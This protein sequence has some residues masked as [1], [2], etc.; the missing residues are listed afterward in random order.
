MKITIDYDNGV[1]TTDNKIEA[2]I[3][4]LL[5]IGEDFSIGSE[6]GLYALRIHVLRGFVNPSDF[7]L[8]DKSLKEEVY[9]DEQGKLSNYGDSIFDSYLDEL[10][11]I[12]YSWKEGE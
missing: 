6:I 7:T 5:A 2:L 12:W 9:L 3:K 1:V 10:I 8:Y 4:A 11:G